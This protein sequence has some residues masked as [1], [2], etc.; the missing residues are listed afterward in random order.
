[1]TAGATALPAAR[2]A[3][4]RGLFREV[5]DLKR[6]RVAHA[7]GSAAQRAFVRAWAALVTGADPGRVA[8]VECAAAVAGARL[9]G[10]DAGVL[11]ACGLTAADVVAVLGRAVDEVAHGLHPATVARVHR[12]LPELV[13]AATEADV[14]G[15]LPG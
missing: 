14:G 7:D 13:G 1:M 15:A 10:M 11:V 9:A 4:T 12:A 2:L 8:A 6:V 3:A 5:G